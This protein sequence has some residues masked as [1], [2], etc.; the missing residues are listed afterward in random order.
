MAPHVTRA[1]DQGSA[2]YVWVNTRAHGSIRPDFRG[3]TEGL[4]PTPIPQPYGNAHMIRGP[5][6][7]GC[8]QYLE[9]VGFQTLLYGFCN[10]FMLI[11]GDFS[12]FG[13]FGSRF[14]A[15]YW[16]EFGIGLPTQILYKLEL[17]DR[18]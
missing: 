1:T 4:G 10:Y 11:L 3:L 12:H 7:R 2:P 18:P 16:E 6:E 9:K 14:E 15:R 8:T 13:G 17:F 5:G